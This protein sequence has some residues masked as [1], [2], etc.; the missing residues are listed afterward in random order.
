MSRHLLF[1]KF[2]DAN[3]FLKK[4]RIGKIQRKPNTEFFIWSSENANL[5]EEQKSVIDETDGS[6]F[7]WPDPSTGLTWLF[8]EPAG[9]MGVEQWN[10]TNYGGHND[11]RTPTLRELETLSSNTKNR[12]GSYVK[13]GLE[14]RISGN[15]ESCTP[16]LHWQDRAWWN[17][18]ERYVTTE[19]Y[20]EG[21]IIWGPEGNY[22]GFEKDRKHNDARRILVRGFDTQPLSDWAINL[23]DWAESNKCFNFPAT[24]KEIEELESLAPLH[25]S[26]LPI[27]ALQLKKLKRL[28]CHYYK[29]MEEVIFSI[30]CLEELTLTRPYNKEQASEEIPASIRELRHL[31]SLKATQL[32][33]LNVDNEIGSLKKLQ[34]L[35]LSYNKIKAIP[36]SIG[37]LGN[38]RL[39]NFGA[40]HIATIPNSIGQLNKLEELFIGGYFDSLPES[41]GNLTRLRKIIIRS[42]NLSELPQNFDNLLNLQTLI[43]GAP[44]RKFPSQ[45]G[46]LK[47]L[48]AITIENSTFESIPKEFS[49]MPSLRLLEITNTPIKSISDEISNMT[50]LER[51]VLTDTQISELPRSLLRLDKLRYLN[52]SSTQLSSLPEWLNEMQSLSTIV[53]NNI[54]FPEA[55]IKKRG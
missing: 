26:S 44:L 32:G 6:Q 8:K 10:S 24:Q 49:S 19:Q 46:L 52:V 42:S 45:L 4:I 29:D 11:W 14:N 13:E 9:F 28:Y 5:T 27:E 34:T 30:S 38:L 23:R 35:D 20:S 48:Q 2:S 31:L 53:A 55:L 39:L 18:D 40:N 21:K 1:N 16:H 41:I 33:L 25:A 17:V 7:V 36:T 43:C 51:L 50:N 54:K 37:E 22:A 47:N 3:N 12:F 15:Y